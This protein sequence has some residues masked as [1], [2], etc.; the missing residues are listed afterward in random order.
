MKTYK[1]YVKNPF[2][3]ESC[4]AERILVEGVLEY[5][6]KYVGNMKSVGL[7]ISRHCGRMDGTGT[8]GSRQLD[9]SGEKFRM[10]HTYIL[11]NESEV[12]PYVERHMC[13]LRNINRRAN[14]RS[15]A[16]EHN[17]SFS[18]WFKNEVLR[19]LKESSHLVSDRLRSLA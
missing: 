15:L 8:L 19:E 18:T 3:P 10:A 13:Y 6:S 4:I 17:R 1:G 7:P 11:F 2:R 16:C 12:V 5:C 14:A 9:I